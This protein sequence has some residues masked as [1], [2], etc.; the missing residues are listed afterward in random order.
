MTPEEKLDLLKR[1]VEEEGSQTRVARKISYSTSAVNLALKG[2]Y[3]AGL[4]RLLAR[5]VE[6]YGSETLIC[7]VLGKISLG[8][9]AEERQRPFSASNP[10]RVRLFRAC[11]QCENNPTR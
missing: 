11:K 7:P 2:K 3:G 10:M 1:A 9:C 6:V 5:V 8:R 4:D